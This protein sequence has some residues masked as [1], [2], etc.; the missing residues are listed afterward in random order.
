MI[1][2][3]AHAIELLGG[4]GVVSDKTDRPLTTVASWATR[5]SIPVEAWPHLILLAEERHLAGFTYE[6]LVR[7]HV[8]AK[9]NRSVD[10]PSASVEA[11]EQ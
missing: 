4:H 3:P 2:T 6:A 5:Q 9:A 8:T 10:V 7:A 1:N 11:G